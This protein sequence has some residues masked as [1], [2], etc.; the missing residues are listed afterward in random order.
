MGRR[1]CYA[2]PAARQVAYRQRLAQEMIPVNRRS[3]LAW[4]TRLRALLTAMR[5]AAATGDPLAVTL[6]HASE[7]RILENL[8]AWFTER[9]KEGHQG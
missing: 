4:E 6:T 7:A 2:T 8:T 1:K 5:A 9:R 3:L